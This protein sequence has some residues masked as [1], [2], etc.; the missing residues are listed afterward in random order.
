MVPVGQRRLPRQTGAY[1]PVYASGDWVQSNPNTWESQMGA[2]IYLNDID[3]SPHGWPSGRG[4]RQSGNTDTQIQEDTPDGREEELAC[5][6]PHGSRVA[7]QFDLSRNEFN[8]ANRVLRTGADNVGLTAGVAASDFEFN[9]DVRYLAKEATRAIR[10]EAAFGH[11]APVQA[12]SNQ[13]Q[14]DGEGDKMMPPVD[15]VYEKEEVIPQIDVSAPLGFQGDEIFDVQVIPGPA[16]IEAGEEEQYDNKRE[17]ENNDGPNPKRRRITSGSYQLGE[18]NDD[19]E[20]ID[21]D[22]L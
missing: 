12:D 14:D 8:R 1:C 7:E 18:V 6:S 19:L 17:N 16:R 20:V 3:V 5:E 4:V 22:A 9:W 15:D 2:G 13:V 21:V 10:S 11:A